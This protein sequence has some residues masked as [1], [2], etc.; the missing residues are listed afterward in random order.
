MFY[1]SGLKEAPVLPATVLVTGCYIDMFYGCT[2]LASVKCL[3]TDISAVGCLTDWLYAVADQGVFVKD[4]DTQWPTGS[5]GIPDGW[6][7]MNDGDVPGGGN[8]GTGDED[9][10]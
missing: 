7:V 10:D 8:E 4:A 3:A 5:S 2:E 1:Y 9:M 6:T